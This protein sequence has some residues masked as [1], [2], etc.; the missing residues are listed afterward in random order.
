MSP[1]RETLDM[2]GTLREQVLLRL[3]FSQAPPANLEGLRAVYRA[4]CLSVPFDNT[5]KMIAL[6]NNGTGLPGGR[7][8]QF[9]EDWLAGGTGGT[10]WPTSNALF[11]LVRSVGF[12]AQRVAGCMRDLGI[13]NHGSVKVTIDGRQ[14][15]VDSSLLSD[16]PL[17]LDHQVFIHDDP[18]FAFEVE[19]D[20]SS[21]VVWSHTPPNSHSLPCRLTVDSV[22][23][24]YYLA[25]YEESRTRSPFNQRLYA[26]RNRPGEMVVFVGD[27]RFSKTAEG[28]VSRVLSPDEIRQA[29]HND[30]GLSEEFIDLWVHTGCLTDSLA[31]P[32]GP[33]PPPVTRKPPS[34]R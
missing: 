6:R 31:P 24:S 11:E 23:C 19:Y 15:L 1:H 25:R 20:D 12:R 2:D 18:V 29:L 10:C 22:D 4:W 3:G 28:T 8:Q 16:V 14:W 27:T 34:Q 33:K 5:R 9:F 32:V 21:H 26:R 17:P 13:V 7:A 30:M